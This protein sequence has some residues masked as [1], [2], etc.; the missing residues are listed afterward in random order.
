MIITKGPPRPDHIAELTMGVRLPLEPVKNEHLSVILETISAAWQ[1]LCAA[2]AAALRTG[3]EAEVSA[4]LDP[5]LNHFCQSLPLW[6]DLVHSVH[7]GRESMSYDGSKLELRPDLSF[8]FLHGNRN[9][10]MAVECK[11]IDHRNSK[12]V[13]LYCTNGILR[14]VCGDYAWA[15]REAI[16]LAY[17]RDGSSLSTRLVPHLANSAKA[18]P[19][20]MQTTSL[21]QSRI[22]IHPAVHHTQHERSFRYPLAVDGNDPGPI[23]L[24]HLWL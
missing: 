18:S 10:P 6:K 24:Y 13:G 22:D 5:R 20:P 8:I 14:F 9:F 7:R 4:L 21:P 23:S 3:D 17:V 12:T 11:I 15:N 19:D 2:G 1:E 16:M